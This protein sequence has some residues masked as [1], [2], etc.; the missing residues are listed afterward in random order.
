MPRSAAILPLLFFA[1]CAAWTGASPPF[2]ARVDGDALVVVATAAPDQTA[3]VARP[4]S[5]YP[6]LGP[7]G[8][9][10]T[11]GFPFEERA[12]EEQDHPHHRSLWFAHGDVAGRDFWHDPDN[13]IVPRGAW[14]VTEQPDGVTAALALAWSAGKEELLVEERVLRFALDGAARVVDFDVTLRPAG[15][16]VTFGDTK[17]GTFALRSHPHLRL[18]GKAAHGRAMNSAGVE[19][20]AVWGKR[21]RWVAYQGTVEGRQ[22]GFALFDH[23]ENLRHPTHWHAREYGLV[24]ANPFGI[25]DFEGKPKGTGSFTLGE[26]ESLRLR[27]RVYLFLGRLEAEALDAAWRRYAGADAP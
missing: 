22:A 27:Y 15:G 8:V 26:G 23:P 1:G 25:S 6:V 14:R 4:A 24:A 12:D 11:R 20:K 21:A 5:I 17:E 18:E 7:G 3:F 10:M 19:G 9:R 2:E 13:Q 16:A